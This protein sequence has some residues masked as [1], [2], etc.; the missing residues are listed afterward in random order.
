MW[1][2]AMLLGIA[3]F[4]VAC[5]SPSGASF[6]DAQ[7]TFS[8]GVH[9]PTDAPPVPSSTP[10]P[11]TPAPTRTSRPPTPTITP[12]VSQVLKVGNLRSE[13]RI[14]TDTV[15]ALICP[16][17]TVAF[18]SRAVIGESYWYRVRIETTAADCDP[19]R[20]QAGTEGWA[21]SVLLGAPSY[22]FEYYAADAQLILPTTVRSTPTPKPT[23]TPQPIVRAAPAAP[24]GGRI[25]AICN[26]GTRSS[27]TGRGA[28]SHHGG[29]ARWLYSP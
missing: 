5:G 19:Q 15:V 20:A 29:V 7:A 2:I 14:A 26:D 27:A 10:L 28:C 24:S 9:A 16:D 23:V 13:P 18:I 4:L 6:S 1:R 17:D 8:A 22:A 11:S 3:L 12:P 25:G 21:S